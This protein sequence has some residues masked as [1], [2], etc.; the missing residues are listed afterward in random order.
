MY[1]STNLLFNLI[2]EK[3]VGLAKLWPLTLL[4]NALVKVVLSPILY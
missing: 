3:K 1:G 2:R 4:Q